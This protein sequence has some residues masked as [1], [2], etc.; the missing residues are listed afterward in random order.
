MTNPLEKLVSQDQI[1]S[2]LKR[3]IQFKSVCHHILSKRIVEEKAS[4]H[5]LAIDEKEIQAEVDQ[6][7]RQMKLEKAS[8]TFDWLE[9]EGISPN[10]WEEGIRDRLLIQKLK[11]TLFEKDVEKFFYENRITFDKV[12][13]YQII[14]PYEQLAQELFY[15][16]EEEEISFYEAAHIYDVNEE[17]RSRCGYE[18]LVQRNA[19]PAALAAAV[20]GANPNELIYPIQTEHG[21]HLLLPESFLLAELTDDVRQGILE[22]LFQEWLQRELSHYVHYEKDEIIADPNLVRQSSSR[23]M[24]AAKNENHRIAHR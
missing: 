5:E 6:L 8:D 4:S 2:F 3:N 13:L 24:G 17:R 14:V 10:D 19:L 21:Y 15:Q 12:L 7:R 11:E 23:S 20:F 18:G 1:V 9:S 22:Q 16:V